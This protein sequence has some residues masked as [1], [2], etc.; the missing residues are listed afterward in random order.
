MT[1]KQIFGLDCIITKKRI[2]SLNLRF[3]GGKFLISAPHF[4]TQKQ[5][6]SFVFSHLDWAKSRLELWQKECEKNAKFTTIFGREFEIC[7]LQNTHKNINFSFENTI[8]SKLYWQNLHSKKQNFAFVLGDQIF[9]I[10]KTKELNLIIDDFKKSALQNIIEIYINHYKSKINREIS[11]IS[12]HRMHTRWGS[13]NH[14]KARLNFSLN[15]ATKSPHLIEYVVLH[16][17]THLL[18][19]D[20]GKGFYA[21]LAKHMSD[22]KEREKEINAKK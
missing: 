3:R 20:H 18:H 5:I 10:A 21:F 14:A 17:L 6:E 13:C 12:I 1:N 8:L 9:V 11:S 22:Y 16:E 15:L 7:V 2:K 4:I 19:N